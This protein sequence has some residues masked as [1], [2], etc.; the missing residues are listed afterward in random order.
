MAYADVCLKGHIIVLSWSDKAQEI[1]DNIH[2]PDVSDPRQVVIVTT[3]AVE[4]D[5]RLPQNRGVVVV[6]GNPGWIKTVIL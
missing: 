1:I 3:S 2:A 6:P 5:P 4:L